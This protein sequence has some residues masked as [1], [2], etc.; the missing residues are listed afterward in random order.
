MPRYKVYSAKATPLNPFETPRVFVPSD[1]VDMGEVAAHD[2]NRLITLLNPPRSETFIARVEMGKV[3]ASM[4]PGDVAQD[5]AGTFWM[6]EF[7]GWRE[8]PSA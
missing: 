1:Y 5:E 2:L 3:H 7:A 4:S 8:L 6:C